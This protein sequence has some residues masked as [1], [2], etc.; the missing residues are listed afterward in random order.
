M[1]NRYS[2]QN[3][4]NRYRTLTGIME[5]NIPTDDINLEDDHIKYFSNMIR[6]NY[7]V[8]FLTE[9]GNPIVYHECKDTYN[10]DLGKEKIIYVGTQLDTLF[11]IND[12]EDIKEMLENYFEQNI[13]RCICNMQHLLHEPEK[14]GEVYFITVDDE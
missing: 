13:P 11:S 4:A 3:I 12:N 10:P 1:E 8:A 6:R 9:L 5:Q 14:M 2:L 7:C